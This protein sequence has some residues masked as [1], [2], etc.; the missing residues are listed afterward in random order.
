[1]VAGNEDPGKELPVYRVPHIQNVTKTGVDIC[2]KTKK[3]SAD[4]LFYWA[5]WGVSLDT[6]ARVVQPTYAGVKGNPAST[7]YWDHFTHYDLSLWSDPSDAKHTWEVRLRG[8]TPG[9]LYHYRVRRRDGNRS[10]DLARDVVFRTAPGRSRKKFSFVVM[11]DLFSYNSKDCNDLDNYFNPHGPWIVQGRLTHQL[12]RLKKKEREWK[13]KKTRGFDFAILPGDISNGDGIFL[14]YSRRYF[15]FLGGNGWRRNG[16]DITK[17]LPFFPCPGNHDYRTRNAPHYRDAF[18]LLYQA[19]NPGKTWYSFDYG[20]AHVVSLDV[21]ADEPRQQSGGCPRYD[22]SSEQIRWLRDDLSRY[23]DQDDIWKIVYYH[24]PVMTDTMARIF[25]DCGVDFVFCGHHE[26]LKY[27]RKK[28]LDMLITGSG[29][30]RADRD[31][32]RHVNFALVDVVDDEMRIQVIDSYGKVVARGTKKKG[33]RFEPDWGRHVERNLTND[34]F[35]VVAWAPEKVS[36]G[37]RISVSWRL[38]L[39]SSERL[40]ATWAREYTSRPAF[41]DGD[42]AEA[43]LANRS[44]RNAEY[45]WGFLYRQRFTAPGS[46]GKRYYRVFAEVENKSSGTKYLRWSYRPVRVEV[47]PDP[48]SHVVAGRHT[49]EFTRGI[50]LPRSP[51]EAAKRL[52]ALLHDRAHFTHVDRSHLRAFRRPF[53]SLELFR[54][55][56]EKELQALLAKSS[57]TREEEQKIRKLRRA[58][59]ALPAEYKAFREKYSNFSSRDWP[60]CLS[61]EEYIKLRITDGCTS[62][63]KTFMTLAN[64]LG[65][66][67][68]MRL[69]VSKCYEDLK[70]LRYLLGTG[71][72][73]PITINGHQMVLAKWNGKWH[74]IN[75]T[76]Y[77]RPKG[78]QGEPEYEIFD[79]VNGR[80]IT[81]NTLL[82]QS[83]RLPGFIDHP[84]HDHL[85]FV[86]IGGNRYDDLQARNWKNSMRLGTAMPRS[87][88]DAL[89]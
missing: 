72:T 13:G 66:Y 34:G 9:T 54:K 6:D 10:R 12:Y 27:R 5:P 32:L 8:L 83:V 39:D 2:W 71:W 75:V 51:G 65:L 79:R 11:A 85:V 19:R 56:L 86:A 46:E 33:S 17:G 80:P 73:P 53:F 68:D 48:K 7:D 45:F 88:F 14:D 26:H 31:H 36:P 35:E 55:K 61:G 25:K 15:G 30:S 78:G 43:E 87:V 76:H 38:K 21:S 22:A 58:I 44:G 63:S 62:F 37:D 82:Y 81:P 29:G 28:G 42:A 40:V 24:C 50:D 16:E 4:Y 77:R 57:R 52:V 59:A 18:Y 23:A 74:L 69:V 67:E 49:G 70:R 3:A 60:F 89:P 84:P 41:P 20:N 64:R 1:V 47:R